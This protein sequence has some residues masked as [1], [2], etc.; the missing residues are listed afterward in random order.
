MTKSDAVNKIK[1]VW[2]S[3]YLFDETDLKHK[4]LTLICREHGR[5]R[6]DYNL[7]IDG[8][9][10]PKC[11]EEFK[12]TQNDFI[13]KAKSLDG[14]F[15]DYRYTNYVDEETPILI[16]CPRHH[17]TFQRLPSFF[18]EGN[19]CSSCQRELIEQQK[20][21]LRKIAETNNHCDMCKI[22]F[23]KGLEKTPISLYDGYKISDQKM[24]C[25]YCHQFL[26]LQTQKVKFLNKKQYDEVKYDHAKII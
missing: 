7:F 18:L 26:R 6:I 9:G 15:H 16:R 1:S 3:R 8:E 20:K 5:F 13:R 25:P 17:N 10:C 22:T 19:G 12:N 24:L 14:G 2:G 23:T 21:E 11:T 4:K